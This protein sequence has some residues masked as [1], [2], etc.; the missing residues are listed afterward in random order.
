MVWL[1]HCGP[2]DAIWRQRS[3]STLAQVM[4]WCLTAPSHYL[5][6]CWLII[7]KVLWHSSE[8]IIMRR[9]ED[10]NQLN[11]IENTIFRMAS[12]SP[13]GQW[14]KG[15]KSLSHYTNNLVYHCNIK[16]SF[17]GVGIPILKIKWSWENCFFKMG[18]SLLVRQNREMSIWNINRV[19][20]FRV[21][22]DLIL[23]LAQQN[24]NQ[25]IQ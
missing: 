11:N 21:L 13:R 3:G 12:R 7:S 18:I 22:T 25:N 20:E 24:N 8:G 15:G 4:A 10:T 19:S 17:L 9:Y 1:T 5:N 16:N 6:Q 2:S 14:V 23:L